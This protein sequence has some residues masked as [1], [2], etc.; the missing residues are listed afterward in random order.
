MGIHHGNIII[1][2]VNNTGAHAP[3][4]YKFKGSDIMEIDKNI[5]DFEGVK[6]FKKN[7]PQ[8]KHDN[9]Y[10]CQSVDMDGN[11][12]DT[13]YGANIVTDYGLN[14]M[15]VDGHSFY[16]SLYMYLG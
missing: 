3:D 8:F 4:R 5:I 11:I 1:N 2:K 15:M 16:G 6:N 7:N 13:K 14:R 10:V 12:V 9:I